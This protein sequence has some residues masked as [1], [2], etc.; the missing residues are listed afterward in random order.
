MSGMSANGC[1]FRAISILERN[2]NRRGLRQ[3]N[4]VDGQFL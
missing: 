2:K 4:K 1:P 3:L